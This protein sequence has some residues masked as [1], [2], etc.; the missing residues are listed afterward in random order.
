MGVHKKASSD[1]LDGAFGRI[2]NLFARN[3]LD[4]YGLQLDEEV[5][6][7]T[8]SKVFRG[9]WRKSKSNN[10]KVAIKVIDEQ[11]ASPDFIQNFL[12]REIE[13]SKRLEHRNLLTTM[14]YFSYEHKTYIVTELG[15]FDL[16][17]LRLKGALRESLARRLFHELACGIQFM[18]DNELVHRDIKC[19]N[20]LITIDGT[21]KVADFGFARKFTNDDLSKTYC[22]STAY[23][24][25]EVLR[26][27]GAYNAMLSDT[28]SCGVILFIIL[29]GSMPF[30]KHNL[31]GII[32]SQSVQVVFPLPYS[33]RLSG[34][35]CN[36]VRSVLDFDPQKRTRLRDV[37]AQTP[38]W[39]RNAK[40][41]SRSQSVSIKRQSHGK[42]DETPGSQTKLVN[43]E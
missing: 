23:T 11:T 35:S 41:P 28:W 27:R 14:L 18:H 16:L 25:P 5:G 30:N 43:I 29:T 9:S 1:M 40:N 17:Y 39:Y 20:L 12:P 13:I 19:E 21:L 36:L 15:R 22:G 42:F 38:L 31:Q 7:G 33:A 37:V 34:D 2:R 3:E 26:A 24:A 10:I 32:K 6:A 4:R 8:Y